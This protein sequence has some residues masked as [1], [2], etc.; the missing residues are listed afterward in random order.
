MNFLIQTVHNIYQKI[1]KKYGNIYKKRSGFVINN[2]VAK[3]N[4]LILGARENFIRRIVE[5][6]DNKL[7]YYLVD[8]FP[9]EIEGTDFK[10]EYADLN[11]RIPYPDNYFECIVSDQLIEHLS[12]PDTFIKEIKRVANKNCTIIMGSE[13]LAAWHNIFALMLTLHPFSDHY[14]ANVR[15]GNPLSIHHKEKFKDPFM[16]HFKIP[17][18]RALR[19]LLEYYNFKIMD[20]QGFGHLLPFGT[21]YDKYH[22]IQFVIVCTNTG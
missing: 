22:S 13:N 16:R 9:F 15:I 17:T 12:Q 1:R 18:I 3:E 11:E 19:E 2:I 7:S 4:I 8:K 5:H 6:T 14:S 21:L 10:F 20:I